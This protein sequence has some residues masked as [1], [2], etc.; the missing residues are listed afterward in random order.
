MATLRGV[1]GQVF[2]GASTLTDIYTVPASKNAVFKVIASNTVT[3]PQTF[4]VSIALNGDPDNLKQYIAYDVPMLGSDT[5]STV[6][7]TAQTGAV[8]RV[9]S[10]L[11]SVAF[12]VTGLEQDE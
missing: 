10:L 2:P 9:Q 7:V 12:T 5:G 3:T 1:L 6:T 8:I 11:G 4:R